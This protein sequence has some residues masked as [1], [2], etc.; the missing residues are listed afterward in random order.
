MTHL[1]YYLAERTET[2]AQGKHIPVRDIVGFRSPVDAEKLMKKLSEFNA[3]K[4]SETSVHYISRE[5]LETLNE[6]LRNPENVDKNQKLF[7][8]VWEKCIK[9]VLQTWPTDEV[10]PVLDLLRWQLGRK[11]SIAVSE[12]VAKDILDVM[13]T[14]SNC[15]LTG[16]TAETA[17]R[18]ILRVLPNLF[19]HPT[20]HKILSD[21]R[22]RI[23]GSLN[24][25]VEN[26]ES[27]GEGE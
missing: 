11:G 4:E 16:K 17:S 15:L 25:F 8:E 6:V 2:F 3:G 12:N 5:D 22:E 26:Y 21:N 7:N 1:L 20:L 23:V 14:S 19:L 24:S 18:L 27:F 13:L 9:P 10:F